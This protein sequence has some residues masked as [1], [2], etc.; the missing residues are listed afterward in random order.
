MD[1]RLDTKRNAIGQTISV[2]FA[3]EQRLC[4]PVPTPFAPKATTFATVSPRALVRLEAAQPP[5]VAGRR[6]DFRAT[7]D[8]LSERTC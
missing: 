8:V 4:R 5:R 6:A 2:R 7:W 1:A 3:E